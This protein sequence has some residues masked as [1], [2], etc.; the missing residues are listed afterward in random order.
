MKEFQ[1][2]TKL[3]AEKDDSSLD[4]L[5]LFL[6]LTQVEV[7]LVGVN[8]MTVMNL[9]GLYSDPKKGVPYAG[10]FDELFKKFEEGAPEF[11]LQKFMN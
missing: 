8:K 9:T 5:D 3:I 6:S 10:Q 7:D 1:R 11:I 4:G 2:W